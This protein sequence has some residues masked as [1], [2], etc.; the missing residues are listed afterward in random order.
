MNHKQEVK[1][2]LIITLSVILV[3]PLFNGIFYLNKNNYTSIL[4]FKKKNLF[5]TDN[6][7]S[8]INYLMYKQFNKS[9][10]EDTIVFGLDN[11]LFLGNKQ[12]NVI[13]KTN[14]TYRP[15]IQ[16]IEKWTGK[17]K[18]LQ[19]FYN[20][21]GIIFIIVIAPNKHTIYKEKLLN[22]FEYNGKTIT[23]D[24][25]KSANI[26]KINML[27]LRGLIIKE[28]NINKHILYNKDD[29]HWNNYTASLAYENTINYINNNYNLK[30]TKIKYDL[31][32]K[33][34]KLA[35]NSRQLKIDKQLNLIDNIM[36]FKFKKNKI[37][38]NGINYE[39]CKKIINKNVYTNKKEKSI[40]NPNALNI[41]KLLFLTDSFSATR[42]EYIGNSIL[43]NETF[44]TV[45]KSHYDKLNGEKLF[46]FIDKNK[47]DI[48][49]YQVVERALYNFKIINSF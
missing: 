30:L 14:G 37:C 45:Y 46:N 21:K 8:Y 18:K 34:I 4:D 43:Y 19:D 38:I 36:E 32:A 5:S 1:Y 9:L 16:K 48:V 3:L 22:I 17:L 28:K 40:F 42:N 13:D 24:I 12:N 20:K 47:V 15:S 39:N 11:F 27:D 35:S 25:V 2:F 23:D 29:S 41:E 31:K 49:I 10:S 6:L 44:K 33:F 7:E 26:Q